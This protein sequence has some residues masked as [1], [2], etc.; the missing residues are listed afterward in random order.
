MRE[1]IKLKNLKKRD[2]ATVVDRCR[3]LPPLPSPR[4]AP[5]LLLLG[6][7][8]TTGSRKSKEGTRDLHDIMRNNTQRCV[9]RVSDCSVYISDN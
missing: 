6:Y 7:A 3:V 5:H 2:C 9:L 4:F 8:V 1:L